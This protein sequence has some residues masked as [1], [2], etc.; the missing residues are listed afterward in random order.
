V[1]KAFYNLLPKFFCLLSECMG[2]LLPKVRI[3]LSSPYTTITGILSICFEFPF[4]FGWGQKRCQKIFDLH[5]TS[6]FQKISTQ[7]TPLLFLCIR[8][9]FSSFKTP[10][11]YQQKRTKKTYIFLISF[12]MSNKLQQGGKIKNQTIV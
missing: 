10:P 12:F 4:L 8:L 11:K 9:H 5:E 2:K 6:F 1:R 3:S 7:F